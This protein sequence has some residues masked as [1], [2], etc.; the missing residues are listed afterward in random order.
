MSHDQMSLEQVIYQIQGIGRYAFR[1]KL[2]TAYIP[3]GPIEQLTDWNVIRGEGTRTYAEQVHDFLFSPAEQ[4]HPLP[5][6]VVLSLVPNTKAQRASRADV[7]QISGPVAEAD[8]PIDWIQTIPWETMLYAFWKRHQQPEQ[9][10]ADWLTSDQNVSIVRTLLHTATPAIKLPAQGLS[11]LVASSRPASTIDLHPESQREIV[12]ATVERL[13]DEE[14][15]PLHLLDPL[16]NVSLS[17]LAQQIRDAQKGIYILHIIAHGVVGED[18]VGRLLFTTET[19]DDATHEHLQDLSDAIEK[20]LKEHGC[21]ALVILNTCMSDA[22]DGLRPD[23]TLARTLAR[24]GVPY[25]VANQAA[26]HVSEMITFTE[27][28]YRALSRRNPVDLAM[29]AGRR[30]LLLNYNE[31][32]PLDSQER[33]MAP[34]LTSRGGPPLVNVGAGL[35]A[36]SVPVL[37][38]QRDSEGKGYLPDWQPIE[39]LLWPLD[40]KVMVFIDDGADGF[41]IDECPVTH[42]QFSRGKL[43]QPLDIRDLEQARQQDNGKPRV[44]VSPQDAHAHAQNVGKRL[45]TIAQWQAMIQRDPE[46]Y[47][48]TGEVCSTFGA[49]TDYSISPDIA[50]VRAYDFQHRD[51]IWDLVGNVYEIVCSGTQEPILFYRVS[52]DYS[53]KKLFAFKEPFTPYTA[54]P[55]NTVG[56]RTVAVWEDFDRLIGAG[57]K[58]R[59]SGRLGILESR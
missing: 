37:Y 47:A 28:F 40:G 42:E 52:S 35:P 53:A 58:L 54:G 46:R 39:R 15:L 57:Y 14:H 29:Q 55:L 56:F 10:F 36:W 26:I 27:A 11:V 12:A 48:S 24:T 9:S 6:R 33:T 41:Y 43:R 31:N 45:P 51:E 8:P 22:S 38:I 23:D 16:A 50:N 18:S 59:Q 2:D 4:Q 20:H 19:S 5:R 17:A 7:R 49:H 13:R 1:Q 3:D 32:K 25:V 44:S 34:P 30:A 21:P